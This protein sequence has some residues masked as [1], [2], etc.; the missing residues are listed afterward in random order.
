[1]VENCYILYSCDGTYEPI[2]SNFSGLS[3]YSSSFVTI[4]VLSEQTC[5]Y[6]LSLGEIECDP[7]YDIDIV[8]GETCDC[9]CYCYFIRS[10]DQTSDVTYVNCDN[11]IVV[12]TIQQGL[13]YNI[14][15]KVFPQFDNQVQIPIKLTDICE[16]NQCP[17][18]IPTVKPTN[19]C[20]V[21]TIF[22]MG[23]N[24]ITQQPSSERDFDGA[25][26]LVV[27]GGTPPYTIFWEVGSFAPALTNLGIGEYS[28]SVTDYYGDFSA[29][30]TC[31]LTAETITYSGMCFVLTGVVE[32]QLVY[33]TSEVKGFK[34]TYPYYEIQYGVNLLGYVFWNPGDNKW[35][36]CETL[37]CQITPY[38]T[39]VS[40][41]YLYP[42][43]DTGNWQVVSDTP[44]LI[45]ES[46][47][48]SCS[49][50]II[51]KEEVTLCA[52]IV[53][54]STK[55]GSATI[56]NQVQ[57]D[58]SVDINGQPSWSSSTGQYVVYWDS[59][60]TP[61]Q[62]VM[63][64]FTSPTTLV[65]NNDPSYP[66]ISNWQVFG[67]PDVY[68]VDIAQGACSDSYLVFASAIVNNA[69]C[70]NN[71]SIT[72]TASGGDA[73]YQ[74]SI[75]AGLSYQP[76]PIF[77]NV[78]PGN[79]TIFV[80]DVNT[81]VGSFGPVL[82]NNIPVTVYNVTMNV[83]YNNNTF[84]L[85]APILPVGS[86]IT[87]DVIMSSTFN[88]FPQTLVTIP[89]YNNFTTINGVGLMT[90]TNTTANTYPLGGPCSVPG[91][92][93]VT[94]IS[95]TYLNTLTLTSGQVI[96]GS[97]TNSIINAPILPCSNATGYYQL[98]ITNATINNCQCCQANL[99]N[100]V[101]PVPQSII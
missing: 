41:G 3:A 62:W 45:V 36:F 26:E 24:C 93:N 66:P 77:N 9:Q 35:F 69:L 75:N 55:P 47:I 101:P 73:P 22:P 37:E 29:F 63:T 80:K 87:L 95:N 59:G 70:G 11:E 5:V 28:A 1:M 53:I 79:Y 27:T 100:S 2:I 33:I 96:S 31:V 58:P 86:T 48:G 43:G 16:N 72:V 54:R 10:A 13:T 57:L 88:Y 84:T 8:S 61:S 30:T 7:T 51:P 74:Y 82:V 19:E 21:I 97:T 49:P 52:T 67:S 40:S 6:V 85:T 18:T 90:N 39:L 20:D 65:T 44:Y 83:N 38:N 64:G 25:V 76:S 50:P 71:G 81:T 98:S 42:T 89:T 34:N 15:S 91:P 56:A 94:Q 23:V 60:S 4:E 99:I 14:C 12:D 68:S 78:L 32:D 17:P 46:T 92:V